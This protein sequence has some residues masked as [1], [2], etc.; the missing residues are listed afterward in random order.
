MT[1]T[2]GLGNECHRWINNNEYDEEEK[3]LHHDVTIQTHFK[4]DDRGEAF[5]P[6]A[7]NLRE[8]LSLKKSS[9]SAQL[10]LHTSTRHHL[11]HSIFISI[12]YLYRNFSYDD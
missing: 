6:T 11:T 9:F 7:A 10:H 4:I 1:T 8:A 3:G 12:Q 2:G 5:P